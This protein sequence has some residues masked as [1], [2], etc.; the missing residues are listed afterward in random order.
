MLNAIHEIDILFNFWSLM[1]RDF[2]HMNERINN[3]IQG[4]SDIELRH[5]FSIAGS[6]NQ[7]RIV[8]RENFFLN[9][10]CQNPKM[11]SIYHELASCRVI[12]RT[13]DVIAKSFPGG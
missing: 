6:N 13:T 11:L 3:R 12:S 8:R 10:K 2:T 9:G 4:L 7:R 1:D 5:L